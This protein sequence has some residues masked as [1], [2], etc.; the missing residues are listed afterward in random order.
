MHLGNAPIVAGDKTI[1][2]F[3]EEHAVT[4]AQPA[5][6]AKIQ[7][8][9]SALRINNQIALMHICVEKTVADRVAQK[10]LNDCIAQCNKIITFGAQCRHVGHGCAVDPFSRQHAFGTA[11]P[12]NLRHAKA[13][14]IL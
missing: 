11:L 7:R 1:Q 5:S 3:S 9:Q 4:F 10:T 2:N 13:W 6:D 14:I 8:H 12:I